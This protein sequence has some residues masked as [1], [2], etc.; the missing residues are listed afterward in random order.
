MKLSAKAQRSGGR[1]A[2]EVPEI[3]GLYTQAKRLEQ[4]ETM[5]KDAAALMTGRPET[6][7]VVEVI[8]EV[9]KST[10]EA[11]EAANEY[12]KQAAEMQRKATEQARF[13]ATAM[14]ASGMTVRDI[15]SIM[16]VSFQRASQILKG[17]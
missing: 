17:S 14:K 9:D 7:F 16:G 13:A 10:M 5:V 1:W 11:V 6:D 4:V 3:Q 8:P 12:A 2:I 15:G